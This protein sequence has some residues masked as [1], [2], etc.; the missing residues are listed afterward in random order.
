MSERDIIVKES[1]E[2]IETLG[3]E[4]GCQ[5]GAKTEAWRLSIQ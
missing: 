2:T 4:H 5:L 1:K 3:V